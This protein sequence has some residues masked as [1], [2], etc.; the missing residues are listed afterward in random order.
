MLDLLLSMPGPLAGGLVVAASVAVAVGG[1]TLVRR[2]FGVDRLRAGN[3]VAGLLYGTL[4]GIYAV[5]LAFVLVAVWEDFGR[6]EERVD[7]EVAS[8]G[9]MFRDADRF[10][11]ADRDRAHE[12]LLAYV[13]SVVD[14]EWPAMAHGDGSPRTLATYG[15]LWDVY[16]GIQPGDDRATVFYDQSIDRL[17]A[18]GESRRG[19]VLASRSGVPPTMWLLLLSGAVIVVGLSFMLGSEHSGTHRIAVASLAAV[20]SSVLFVTVALDRPFGAGITLSK[21]P[22]ESLYDQWRPR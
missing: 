8:L 7:G 5:L 6:A 19:R 21:H 11:P 20:I 3:E 13:R 22:Y 16:Q 15:R 17:A 12:A 18:V 10:P 14:D 4:A 9:T 2:R 1:L